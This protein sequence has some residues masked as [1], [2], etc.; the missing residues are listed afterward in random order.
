MTRMS[1]ARVARRIAAGAAYGGG[2]VGLVGAAAIGLVLAEVRFVK[3]HVGNGHAPGSNHV[4]SADGRYG[5]VYDTPGEP[6]IR[7]TMLG[8][9]TAAGQ[10]VHR[11]AQTPGAL[12]ASGTNAVTHSVTAHFAVAA[13]LLVLLL[14]ASRP[15]VLAE[16]R[17]AAP[18]KQPAQ[19]RPAEE[20]SAEE[21]SAKDGRK[22]LGN[23]AGASRAAL[24]L[25]CAMV[26][27]TVTGLG[28]AV[29]VVANPVFGAISDRT[30]SRFGR[31]VPWIVVGGLTGAVALL[32]L[33][34]ADSV[35]VMALGWCL[36]QAQHVGPAA[37]VP[38]RRPACPRR[39]ECLAE[40]RLPR[41]HRLPG[42]RAG[43]RRLSG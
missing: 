20:Q 6:P 30:V 2:G 40:R 21:Q 34:V 43:C 13:A 38:G 8:D 31:R 25:G 33:A 24:W 39:P 18:G 23:L 12:L 1:R 14:A 32:V 16:G 5:H 29:S 3:R 28:A 7:L 17:E 36:A 10:G 11:A 19:E 4:P 35:P 9:S 26:F 41:H 42:D 37:D 27:G 22:R 15:R